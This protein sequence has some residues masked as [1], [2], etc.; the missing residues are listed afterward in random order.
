MAGCAMDRQ[1][2]SS[3]FATGNNKSHQEITDLPLRFFTNLNPEPFPIDGLS[4]QD[5][6]L[7]ARGAQNASQ[8]GGS[9]DGIAP[10]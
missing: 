2:T 10:A 9:S 3:R 4:A 8:N 7:A 1:R 6:F 5:Y